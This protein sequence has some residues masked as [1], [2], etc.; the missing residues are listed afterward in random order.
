MSVT[1]EL[2]DELAERLRAEAERHGQALPEYVL[3]IL[4]A[5]A[6][7]LSNV[8][9]SCPEEVDQPAYLTRLLEIVQAFPSEDSH[10]MPADGAQQ[11]DHYVY[12]L[13]KRVADTP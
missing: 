12:G 6:S 8:T 13:P 10:Q 4:E 2:P 11:I 9:E 5:A 7:E 1:I 3:P